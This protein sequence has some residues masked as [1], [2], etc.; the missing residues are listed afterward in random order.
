MGED[1]VGDGKELY[2]IEG[3]TLVK[4]LVL[5]SGKDAVAKVI[6]LRHGRTLAGEGTVGLSQHKG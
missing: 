3:I 1:V 2:Q 4:F 5:D 6:G